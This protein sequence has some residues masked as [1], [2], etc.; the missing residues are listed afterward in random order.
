MTHSDSIISNVKG[1]EMLLNDST[2]GI[3]D[4]KFF[5]ETIPLAV[6]IV[7]SEG[8]YTYVNQHA[9]G[10]FGADYMGEHLDVH[11]ETINA[12]SVDGTA[13]PTDELPIN[14]SLKHGLVKRDFEMTFKNI[15]GT[16]YRVNV[17]S[18]PLHDS[19]GKVTGAIVIS[20][21][22]TDRVSVKEALQ[23]QEFLLQLSD[24]LR[25][26]SDP[27]EI[28]SAVT[29][30]AMEYFN[31]DRCYYCEIEDNNAIIRRDASLDSLPSVA[32]VYPLD[33]LP[34][35]KDL[36]ESGNPIIVEDVSTTDLVD[37]DLRK[38]CIQLQVISYLDIPVVKNGKPVGLLCVTQCSPRNWTDSETELAKE[39]SERTWM[40]VERAKIE[41]ALKE[42]EKKALYLELEKLNAEKSNKAKN[43]FLSQM[44]HDL[45]TPLNT[46][47]GYSQ[48][49]MM[50]KLDNDL[51]RKINKIFDASEHLLKLMEEILDFSVIDTGEIN[52][53]KEEVHLK[54]FLENCVDALLEINQSDI[55]IH[56]EEIDKDLFIKVDPNRF[57][58]IIT[59]LVNN[60][61]KYN[62][63]NGKVTIGCHYDGKN[64]DIRV[65][66]AD[67][68]F[69][70]LDDKLD[71]IF[72]PFYRSKENRN[73][74]KGTGLGLAIVAQLTKRMNGQYG[75]KT[76]AG[77][78]SEFWVSFK[79]K[80][81]KEK[82]DPIKQRGLEEDLSL[83]QSINVLY[84]EDN[85]NNIDVMRSML[86]RI[87][88]VKFH[89]ATL[90]KQ[91]IKKALEL[92]PNIILLDL[93]LPDI[94]GYEVLTKLKSNPITKDIPVVV[95]SADA[96]KTTIEH[97]L[98]EGSIAYI[99]KPIK[100]EKLRKVIV[101]AIE[102]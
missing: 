49:I 23:R 34:I 46:I 68:G 91:G 8:K 17:S 54:P 74:R 76:E 65:Y 7:N 39:I 85:E 94:H 57:N 84:I 82:H 36:V 25:P 81:T 9:V 31:S 100:F 93:F 102:T 24:T 96:S 70:I 18:T 22:V 42:S 45:R 41:E 99:T 14:Y 64:Q 97:S 63:P 5:F 67:T 48:I 71:A 12:F 56:L 26:L 73:K 61:I 37:E 28:Q 69:G 78:G 79:G 101:K 58:Q 80:I 89:F 62:K 10:Q 35:Q 52:I 87:G 4:L 38:L 16:K 66:I 86:N 3:K 13:I 20:D 60:A 21:N 19:N 83:Q 72:E 77:I 44:S 59:N 88:N 33:S 32:G 1:F 53:N 98:L 55:T 2:K 43:Q 92:Q 47:Q 90:G 27:V 51:K 95:I 75:V 15:N 11:L 6:E 29:R 40:A 30:A 50:N